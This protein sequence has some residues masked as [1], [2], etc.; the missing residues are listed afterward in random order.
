MR[1]AAAEAL[2]WVGTPF[3][4]HTK[5]KGVGCDCVQLALGI[6]QAAGLIPEGEQ[7]PPYRLDVSA[8]LDQSV[9]LEWLEDSGYFEIAPAPEAGALVAFK[10]GRVV[11]HVGVL[12]GPAEFVHC[13]KRYGTVKNTLEDPTWSKRLDSV[14]RPL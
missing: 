1:R 9:V 2:T 11:H 4:P 10:F 8:H 5:A 12:V 6:Y 3:A 13:W 7:F 14:W